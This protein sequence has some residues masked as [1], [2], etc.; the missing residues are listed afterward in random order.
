[1]NKTESVSIGRRAYTCELDAYAVVKAYLERAKKRL[2]KD[3]DQDEILADLEHAMA[4]H[5]DEVCGGLVVD[6]QSAEKVV[7][8][9]GEVEPG[10]MT[11]SDD[12]PAETAENPTSFLDRL[13]LL[14]K[15]PAQKDRSRAILEGV[16]A[17][18]AKLLMID[19]F[20]VRVV[21]IVF[22]VLSQGLGILMY[23]LL[24]L[25]MHDEDEAYV[26]RTA[27]E[28]VGT[29]KERAKVGFEQNAR[30]YERVLSKLFRSIFTVFLKLCNI[31]LLVVLIIL[32]AFW[33]TLLFFMITNPNRVVLFG[34]NPSPLDFAALISLG[35]V[36]LIPILLLI[37]QLAGSKI[38]RNV[39]VNVIFACLWVLSVLLAAGSSINVIP[40]VRDRLVQEKPF[41][42]N[43]AIET[44]DTQ[45]VHSCFTLWGDCRSD[46]PQIFTTS[47]C[48]REVLMIEPS[49]QEMTRMQNLSWR[50]Q[51]EFLA[52]PMSED[53]YCTFVENT[54]NRTGTERVVFSTQSWNDED[55]VQESV[56]DD[57]IICANTSVPYTE[58][59]ASNEADDNALNA[60]DSVSS[61]Q[62][63]NRSC[64]ATNSKKVWLAQYY[65]R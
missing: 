5:L 54:L 10:T 64:P 12:G 24:A 11:S 16:C 48:S 17:G 8:M 27:G 25:I 43:V 7:S 4:S 57:D 65:T 58:Q 33:S 1:M 29:V 38:V 36:I 49:E 22:T 14:F 13:G 41:T 50:Y 35:A 55:Y 15:K 61:P 34:Q 2:Q 9:L 23:I 19:P 30:R 44:A 63:E 37:L 60:S 46:R 20:W 59:Q 47:I 18:M 28:V 21:F 31:S 3:P 42:K 6:K 45:I 51:T 26:G 39:R 32:G 62:E 40:N 52:Y 56:Y 53:V